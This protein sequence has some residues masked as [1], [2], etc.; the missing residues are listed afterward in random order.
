V[1]HVCMTPCDTLNVTAT[2]ILAQIELA[3]L[4]ASNEMFPV[5]HF[6]FTL[7]SDSPLY[8]KSWLLC[9]CSMF[10]SLFLL[11]SP[12]LS[13]MFSSQVSLPI[14]FTLAPR[15]PIIGKHQ[16]SKISIPFLQTVGF[17]FR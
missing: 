10:Q 11:Y 14:Q 12:S 4:W 3:R 6:K 1:V 7:F 5:L 13:R 9:T 8:L 2:T 16:R 17:Y 15:D